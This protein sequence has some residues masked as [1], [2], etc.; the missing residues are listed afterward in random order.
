MTLEEY[1]E[2]PDVAAAGSRLQLTLIDL[3][4]LAIQVQHVRWN[5]R[6]GHDLRNRFDDFEALCRA[7]A[8]AIAERMRH[9]GVAPDGRVGTSYH[10]LLF[11]PLPIGPLDAEEGTAALVHRVA[12]MG[13]RVRQ[14]LAI[15]EKAD[16]DSASVLRAVSDEIAVWPE[17]GRL[18]H[19]QG[20]SGRSPVGRRRLELRRR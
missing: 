6:G 18:A 1:K 10:D 14:S 17:N 5:L 3:A 11:D 12:Q 7:G 15:T 13:D 2:A 9:I 4:D 19:P 20:C 8:D 16:P